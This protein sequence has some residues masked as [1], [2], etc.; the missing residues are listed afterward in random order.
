MMSLQT[1]PVKKTPHP[2]IVKDKKISDGSPIIAGT[3]TRVVDIAIKYDSLGYSPDE[4]A[5]AHPHLNLHQIHDALSYYYENQKE[6]DQ[7]MILKG[8]KLEELKK[9]YS[10]K[11][12]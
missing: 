7:Q 4:I 6:I 8:K 5:D 11:T 12:E 2:Y 9:L 10:L 3:R 1:L